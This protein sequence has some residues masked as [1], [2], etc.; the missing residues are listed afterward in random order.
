MAY[1]QKLRRLYQ[2]KGKSKIVYVDETGFDHSTYRPHGWSLKGRK[3]YGE[4]SGGRRGR[5]NLIAG[6]VGTRLLAPV[7]YRTSTKALW[8]NQWLKDHLLKELP[9]QA[10]VV[11]DNAAFHKTPA[12]RQIL[13]DAGVDLL[14]LPPYSPDFNPIEQDFAI[15]KRRRQFAPKDTSLHDIIKSYGAYLE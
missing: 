3:V 7:L 1:L 15:M 6:K 2:I 13:E 14:Y 8:F 5:L 10:T 9:P 11:M 12:T 4:R